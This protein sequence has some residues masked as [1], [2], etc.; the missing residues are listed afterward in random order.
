MVPCR[1]SYSLV[2]RLA[3]VAVLAGLVW[4]VPL[5]RFRRLDAVAAPAEAFDPRSFADLFW[6]RD[7]TA[8]C[9]A[10][11]EIG[12]VLTAVRSDPVA[13]CQAFGRSPG[14][15]RTCLY[16]VR[17]SGTIV[18]VGPSAC[19]VTLGGDSGDVELATGPV[20]GTAIRDVT[21][22]VDPAARTDSRDLAAAA[23]A[24]NGLALERAIVPLKDAGRVGAVVEFV[25]VGAVQ[26]RLPAGKPW[27]LTPVRVSLEP[28]AAEGVAR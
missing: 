4:Q 5:V 6:S 16:L 22:T 2:G 14:L 13:A 24:I 26:G 12:R 18:D 27:R 17:G 10:A 19:R 3:C 23:S 11:S 8:A 15:S 7:L 1:S 20:F 28:T 21:G 25:A 9:D